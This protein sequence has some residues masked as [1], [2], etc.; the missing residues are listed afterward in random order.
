M[1]I[2]LSTLAELAHITTTTRTYSHQI[3]LELDRK[4]P[5]MHL[6]SHNG[7]D[8]IKLDWD[9]EYKLTATCNDTIYQVLSAFA[10]DILKLLLTL[11]GGSINHPTSPTHKRHRTSLPQATQTL[12]A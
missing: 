6:L 7:G 2:E 4:A 8:H 3:Y 5:M 10:P 11:V 12:T 1:R 9:C